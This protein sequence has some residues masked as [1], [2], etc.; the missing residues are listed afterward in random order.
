ML[1]IKHFHDGA[2]CAGFRS[3]FSRTYPPQDT[4]VIGLCF[5]CNQRPCKGRLLP[6]GSPHQGFSHHLCITPESGTFLRSNQQRSLTRRDKRSTSC[7]SSGS[8]RRQK[9]LWVSR[10]G[11]ETSKQRMPVKESR[12]KLC[13]MITRS[14][15]RGGYH[16]TNAHKNDP[17]QPFWT[18]AIHP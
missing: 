13:V 4:P 5:R 2:G 14:G 7:S 9:L 11:S 10:E 1:W 12:S 17:K 8:S 18:F 15:G 6:L 16:R 3:A